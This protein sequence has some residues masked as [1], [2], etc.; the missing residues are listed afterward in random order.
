MTY[1]QAVSWL[2][3]DLP[4]F[5]LQGAKAYN[6]GLDR[7]KKLCEILGNPQ[8]KFKTIHIA[9]T[10]GKGSTSHMLSAVFQ[11]YGFKVGLHTS[12]HLLEFEERNRINGKNT[13]KEFVRQFIEQ[14]KQIITDLKC[15]F[16]EFAVALGF[17]YF[18][19]KKVDIAIIETG[20]GGRL[21][22]TNIINPELSVITNI[23]L[24]H[25]AILGDTLEKIA[26][27]KAGIIK[28]NK[29]VVIGEFLPETKSVFFNIA[30][31]K[32]AEI[33]FANQGKS[34]VYTTD[35]LGSYQAKNLKTVEKV[36]EVLSTQFEFNKEKIQEGL[37]NVTQ[38]TGLRGRWEVLQENPLIITDT[39]HNP[40]GIASI[41]KQI[42]KIKAEKKII[43]LGFVSD[44]DVKSIL[45]LFPKDAEYYFTQPNN[46]RKFKIE[47][48]KNIVPK[49]LNSKYFESVQKAIEEAQKNTSENDFIFIGG[50][51]FIVSE[52]LSFF[53]N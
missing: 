28:N 22:A 1:N 39:A 37:N 9:G 3:N 14:N 34:P 16:F 10:N 21:D 33:Y 41:I 17:S 42:E 4:F 19:H 26:F 8:D 27:E 31:E 48:L 44:K 50:S 6:P 45:K 25:T 2:Y 12:P 53:N 23:A 38:L 49:N 32:N 15:S 24:E 20:L 5:Q 36:L 18:A 52:G 11:S 35:L 51:N 46:D 13:E 43:I 29:P 40:A 30:K 47:D 7:I